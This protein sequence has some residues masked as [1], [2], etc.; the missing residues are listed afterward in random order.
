MLCALFKSCLILGVPSVGGRSYT[1]VASIS[2]SDLRIQQT[3]DGKG[4]V[5]SHVQNDMRLNNDR[6][7]V[8]YRFI[9]VEDCLRI[10]PATL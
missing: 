2:L 6:A 5:G 7:T 9:L 3:D 10:R 1:I 4:I 8:P